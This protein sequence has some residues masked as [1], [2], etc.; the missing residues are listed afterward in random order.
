ME[1]EKE[2]YMINLD[3]IKTQLLETESIYSSTMGNMMR[4]WDTPERRE[5][6]IEA[7][8]TC[9]DAASFFRLM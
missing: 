9:E 3:S 7:I 6:V 1:I 8:S 5:Q 4:E 2:F